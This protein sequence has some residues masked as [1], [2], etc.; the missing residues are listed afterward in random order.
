MIAPWLFSSVSDNV[1]LQCAFSHNYSPVLAAIKVDWKWV[2]GGGGGVGG[3]WECIYHLALLNHKFCLYDLKRSKIN[4]FCL[5]LTRAKKDQQHH[6]F[7]CVATQQTNFFV[8]CLFLFLSHTHT[9][10][11]AHN[12]QHAWF[13]SRTNFSHI[14]IRSASWQNAR[15]RALDC[16]P[17]SQVTA[18]KG[19]NSKIRN[20]T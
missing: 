9:H 8:V 5:V 1:T 20:R 14:Y 12:T 4:H 15:T 2:I 17:I 18:E 16:R 3:C 7:T 6:R 13:T 19:A 10:N 11:H